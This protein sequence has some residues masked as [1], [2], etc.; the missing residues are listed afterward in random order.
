MSLFSIE[1]K[2]NKKLD[3]KKQNF[4]AADQFEL[5]L[6]QSSLFSSDLPMPVWFS[7]VGGVWVYMDVGICIFSLP[8]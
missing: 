1:L 3:S 8:Y 4:E 2:L 7:R 5:S 6:I